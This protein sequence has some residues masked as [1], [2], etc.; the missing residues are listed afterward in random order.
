VVDDEHRVVGLEVAMDDARA[1]GRRQHAAE[2]TADLDDVADREPPAPAQPS[3]E[4]FAV[5][6]L[7]DQERAAVV[8]ADVVDADD[9]GVLDLARRDRLGEEPFDLRRVGRR[10][11]R[12]QLD[13]DARLAQGLLGRPHL[14][15]ASATDPSDDAEAL[16]DLTDHLSLGSSSYIA[17]RL[18]V[19]RRASQD[20]SRSS[21]PTIAGGSHRQPGRSGLTRR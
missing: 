9:A 4:R 14:P 5:E 15:H 17:P 1:V 19:D 13:R 20:I 2:L 7:H 11:E 3:A 18:L 6:Q 12:E 10:L 8:K 16:D 21:L